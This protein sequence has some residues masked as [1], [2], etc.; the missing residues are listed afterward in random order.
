MATYGSLDDSSMSVVTQLL[1]QFAVCTV[2][3]LRE[4]STGS[5]DF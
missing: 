3:L 2:S 4:L 5:L 1:R